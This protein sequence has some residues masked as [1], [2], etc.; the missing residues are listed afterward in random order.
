MRPKNRLVVVFWA[1]MNGT[2]DKP[3]CTQNES[4]VVRSADCIGVTNKST[5]ALNVG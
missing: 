1:D 4:I 3:I 2:F 5:A